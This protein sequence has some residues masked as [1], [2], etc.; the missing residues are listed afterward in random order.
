MGRVRT[1][2]IKTAGSGTSGRSPVRSPPLLPQKAHLAAHAQVSLFGRSPPGRSLRADRYRELR[3]DLRRVRSSGHV[4]CFR[5]LLIILP[6]LP[7]DLCYKTGIVSRDTSTTGYS[8]RE[9][10][11]E[12]A[13]ND[14]ESRCIFVL[15]CTFCLLSIPAPTC[16]AR[17]DA[18]EHKSL[19][20][21]SKVDASA[22]PS[23]LARLGRLLSP[24]PADGVHVQADQSR[25]QQSQQCYAE[26]RRA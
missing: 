10:V 22:T 24:S 2:P 19:R 16:V 12:E 26:P 4:R 18:R 9:G 20:S 14:L 3:I 17:P 23:A 5:F 13:G 11:K 8:S 15:F 25:L 7:I 1:D 6:S 21:P